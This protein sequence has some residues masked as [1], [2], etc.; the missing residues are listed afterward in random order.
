M[1]SPTGC[2]QADGH[3]QKNKK[4]SI[5]LNHQTLPA[6]MEV[7]KQKK[8]TISSRENMQPRE[9]ALHYGVSVLNDRELLKILI[10]SG[11][12]NR[13]VDAIA[14]D[15]LKLLDYNNVEKLFILSIFQNSF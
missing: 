15:V 2:R 14:R 5:C 8:Y 12:K 10:G 11:Q 4:L 7:M 6:R 9:K 13:P 3:G 1:E